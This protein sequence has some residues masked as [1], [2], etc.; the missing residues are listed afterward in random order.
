MRATRIAIAIAI[1]IT[2]LAATGSLACAGLRAPLTSPAHGGAAWN[3]LTSPHFVLQSDVDAGEARATIL[4]FEELH[5]ALAQVLPPRAIE[6]SGRIEIVLFDRRKDFHALTRMPRTTLAY[7]TARLA[8]D[9]EPQPVLVLQTELGEQGR[10]TF[11][12]ELAHRFLH[13]RFINLPIWLNEGFAQLYSTL[14][15]CDGKITVGGRL[16]E[17]DFSERPFVWSAWYQDQSQIQLPVAQAPTVRELMAADRTVFYPAANDDLSGKTELRQGLYYTAA[18]KLVQLLVNGPDDAL[19]AR[20][21]RFLVALAGG[22]RVQLAFHTAFD[23]AE[24]DRLEQ[25]YRAYLTEVDLLRSVVDHRPAPVAPL[26][27]EEVM[28]EAR[29]HLLWAR[30]IP[31]QHD[32]TAAVRSEIDAAI[33]A[34]PASPDARFLSA[35]QKMFLL[36][37]EGSR[38]DLDLTLKWRPDDP[39]YL[40]GLLEWY[41]GR[42]RKR[43]ENADDP[44]EIDALVERL[45]RVARTPAQ[46]DSVAR[47]HVSRERPGDAFAFAERAIHLDPTCA[48]CEDTRAL[49]L[50]QVRRFPEALAAIDRALSLLPE[51]EDSKAM[52]AHRAAILAAVPATPAPSPR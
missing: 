46:L 40:L 29:V 39:H 24:L 36:D 32:T 13:Q 18:W 5:A 19:R 49:V 41:R 35:V 11:L 7:F 2:I 34:D 28:S 33:T 6:P 16:P 30:L 42:P 50:L 45:A 23:D 51:R 38:A 48:A 3:E 27:R 25:V 43:G 22:T 37:V 14:R 17:S 44:A 47:H 21:Q 52:L 8:P 15:I 10:S 20:F 31:W 26:E 1:T 9:F 12:H 4:Q